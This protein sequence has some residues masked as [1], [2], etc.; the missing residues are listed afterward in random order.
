M[1]S[2][3]L[4]VDRSM[5]Q[6]YLYMIGILGGGATNLS[7]HSLHFNTCICYCSNKHMCLKTTVC[8]IM[9]VYE[10]SVRWLLLGLSMISIAITLNIA[11]TLGHL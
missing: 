5:F 2:L 11:D 10:M 6:L 7:L 4:V 3:W 8:G 1:C 9:F